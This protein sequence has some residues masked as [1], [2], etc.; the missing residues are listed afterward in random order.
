VAILSIRN[1]SKHFGGVRAVDNV[2]AEIEER[3]ITSIIGPNGA[4]KTTL[5]NLI[6]AAYALTDGEIL[7]KGKPLSG[8]SPHQIH[9]NGIARTFQNIRLFKTMTV[10]ENIMIGLHS[11]V[12][13]K[14]SDVFIVKRYNK[15]EGDMYVK[16]MDVLKLLDLD[17]KA[18]QTPGSL[19]Y[20]EQRR[21][22]IARALVSDPE[23]LL[24]DEP[25]AG[26]NVGES[27]DLMM[28]IKSIKERFNKTVIVIEHNMRVVRAI[29]DKIIVLDHGKKIAEGHPTEVLY[30]PLVI[31][32]YLGKNEFTSYSQIN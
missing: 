21:V 20:G 24:L 13:P 10:L 22:E 17:K 30:N 6:T 7:F 18:E 32:A 29:S 14:I 28:F 4:G 11:R 25:A 5:F 31:E 9:A 27:K 12:K 1:V 26:M 3:K 2:S 19:P 16:A 23:I 15:V 8:M